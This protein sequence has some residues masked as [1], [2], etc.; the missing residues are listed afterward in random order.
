MFSEFIAEKG[1][2]QLAEVC[3]AA[4]PTVYGWRQKNR[5]P[6][7]HWDA[8]MDRWPTLRYSH[9]KAMEDAARAKV[10]S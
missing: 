7:V 10:A 2:T 3:G 9:L 4:V 1:V 5:I 8:I 6:R